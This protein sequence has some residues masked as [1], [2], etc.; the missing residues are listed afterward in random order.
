M[1]RIPFIAATIVSLA[2]VTHLPAED[3]TDQPKNVP[4]T[5]EAVKEALN[6]LRGLG[7]IDLSDSA[8]N[9]PQYA[10]ADTLSVVLQA[11][12]FINESAVA[13]LGL[14]AFLFTL[15]LEHCYTE[16]EIRG[17]LPEYQRVMAKAKGAEFAALML[18]RVESLLARGQ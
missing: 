12:Q 15:K 2:L 10:T 7:L 13:V 1:K 4:A 6:Q 18:T 16:A 5:R 14:R 9:A 11:K 17:I 8:A 3:A